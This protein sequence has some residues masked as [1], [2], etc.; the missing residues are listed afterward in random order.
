MIDG[1]PRPTI[2]PMIGLA[3][4]RAAVS[5]W[6]FLNFNLKAPND[7]YIG[8]KK[9]AGLLLETLSQGE[10][11]RLLLGLGI[12]VL[13]APES[14]QTAS[15]ISKELSTA[16]PLLAQDWIAF[17]ERLLFEISFSLQTSFEPMNSTSTNAL[18]LAL[19][20]HPLLSEK[21]VSLDEAGNLTTLT[22]KIPWQEL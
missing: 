2:T 4:Y 16:T 10:D 5:T 6:P 12:N 13:S 3:L 1:P 14:V 15:A 20:R 11:H 18:L 22:R 8:N 17:L 19:N 9:V 7:L 21:Y